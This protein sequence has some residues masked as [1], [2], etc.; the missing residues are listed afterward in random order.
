VRID[1]HRPTTG[2]TGDAAG[3]AKAG[4]V[5]LGIRLRFLR[6]GAGLTLAGLSELSG[7]SLTYLSD[8][9]RGNR[10]P[11]LDVLDRVC[12]AL[13]VQVADLLAGV[14]P[15]G[16]DLEPPGLRPPPDG[17][18]SLTTGPGYRGR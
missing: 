17:R 5:G 10:L 6:S 9:E 1:A 13:G 2:P 15:W 11:A 7:V 8:M 12:S 16:S 14:Y 4:R 3:R 18:A